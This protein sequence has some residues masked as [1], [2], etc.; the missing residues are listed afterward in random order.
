M[1]RVFM[2]GYY[3]VVWFNEI[4]SVTFFYD[5]FDVSW[6]IELHSVTF[7][8]DTYDVV[9][10]RLMHVLYCDTRVTWLQDSKVTE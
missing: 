9:N 1:L 3:V 4:R 6:F 7:F 5:S 2:Y 10:L 8:Y